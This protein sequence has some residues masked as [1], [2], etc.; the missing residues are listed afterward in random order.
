MNNT[1]RKVLTLDEM[2]IGAPSIFADAKHESRSDKY[3]RFPTID[4]VDLLGR[5]KWLPV[6]AHEQKVND[7]RKGFQQHII[8]FWNEKTIATANGGML[9]DT[10]E[11]ILS[12]S[13]DGTSAFCMTAGIYRLVCSN[14]LVV[15]SERYSISVKHI[16]NTAR[17]VLSASLK[18]ANESASVMKQVDRFKAI[19]MNEDERKIFAE[20]ALKLRYNDDGDPDGENDAA[21]EQAAGLPVK[22]RF[23]FNDLLTPRRNADTDKNLWTTYNVVQENLLKGSRRRLYTNKGFKKM[24]AVK[25]IAQDM[26]LN[27]SLWLLTSKMAELKKQ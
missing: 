12:N 20:S 23:D 13:N 2:R 21:A 10:F 1:E 16:G 14:G 4:V 24:R 25:G 5:E 26:K 6:E 9:K 17:D 19:G 18:V 27:K 11:L 7:S 22:T 15:G 8:K 3:E